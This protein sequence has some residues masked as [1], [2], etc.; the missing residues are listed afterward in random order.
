MKK[1]IIN[2]ILFLFLSSNGFSAWCY[3]ETANQSHISDGSCILNY[4]GTYYNDPSSAWLS[5]SYDFNE[6]FDTNWSSYATAT[7]TW[8]GIVFINYSKPVNSTENSLWQIKFNNTIDKVNFSIPLNCWNQDNLQF[9]VSSQFFTTPD[10]S[11][12]SCYNGTNWQYLL[13]HNLTDPASIYEEA[14]WWDIEENTYSISRDSSTFP[15][16]N[17]GSFFLLLLLLFGYFIIG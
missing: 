12:W 10:Y 4:S 15:I 14:M 11:N 17:F 9:K 1:I 2:I 8:Y 3:Q 5:S 7:A 16:T 13:N 6:V